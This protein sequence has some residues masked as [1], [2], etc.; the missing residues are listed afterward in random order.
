MTQHLFVTNL[1]N[2]EIMIGYSYLSII[3]ISIGKKANRSLLDAQIY[4]L[5]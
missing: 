1:E 3:Q 2:K 4:M 5:V